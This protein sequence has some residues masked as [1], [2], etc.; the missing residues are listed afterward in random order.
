MDWCR[1]CREKYGC[2]SQTDIDI[3]IPYDLVNPLLAPRYITQNHSH[4]IHQRTRLRMSLQHS[5]VGWEL[6]TAGHP[7]LG[8]GEAKGTGCPMEHHRVVK[9]S[10]ISTEQPG[11][12]LK[13]Q[14]CVKRGP[15]EQGL[16]EIYT[17]TQKTNHKDIL[18]NLT[19]N[20]ILNIIANFVGCDD[21]TAVR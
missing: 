15:T 8:S 13:P 9:S 19:I 12:T 6:S 18:R 5:F 1:H 14:C 7:F 11:W 20:W 10:S 2:I 4:Q 3:F 17:H 16:Q 21:G